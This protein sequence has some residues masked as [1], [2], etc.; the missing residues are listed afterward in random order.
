MPVCMTHLRCVTLRFESGG[1]CYS[2]G[3]FQVYVMTDGSYVKVGRSDNPWRRLGQ[4]RPF[5]PACVDRERLEVVA[6]RFE[7][8]FGRFTEAKSH[9][10]L[11]YRDRIDKEWWRLTERVAI[12]LTL[13]GLVWPGIAQ[14]SGVDK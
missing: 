2:G 12:I 10:V 5:A 3:T 9:A 4:V 1:P 7:E 6:T 13:L 8:G 14:Y 11:G